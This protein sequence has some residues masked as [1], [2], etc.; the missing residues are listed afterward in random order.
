MKRTD[1][2]IGVIAGLLI[3][4]TL[5]C[6][7]A[8]FSWLCTGKTIQPIHLLSYPL[9][10]G[11]AMLM[12]VVTYQFFRNPLRH[13]QWL[14]CVATLVPVLKLI[15]IS[16]AG[17]SQKVGLPL[18]GVLAM[19]IQV[20][21]SPLIIGVLCLYLWKMRETPQHGDVPNPHSPSAQGSDGR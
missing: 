9:A 5:F 1:R 17:A 2:I 19:S 20:I 21:L 10:F 18:W 7:S 6:L 13:V 3:Y 12:G 14:G 11:F 15:F 8:A 4:E 16:V